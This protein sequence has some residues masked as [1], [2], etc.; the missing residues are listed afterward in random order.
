M[1]NN[2]HIS[3]SALSELHDGAWHWAYS[4]LDRDADAADEVLQDVYVM[5]L[6]GRAHFDNRATLKTWLYSVIRHTCRSHRRTKLR[7]RMARWRY[8]TAEQSQAEQSQPARFHEGT[9]HISPVLVQAL[10]SLPG[11]QRDVIELHLFRGFSLSEC[12]TVLG[13]R[14]GSVR[15][16]Y[17]RAKDN[18]RRQVTQPGEV[19]G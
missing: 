3:Q 9:L 19:G 11:R 17:H 13:L 2:S 18:L 12:A 4:Q 1:A 10:K 6:E 8:F 15:T 7:Y 5:I 16:H 14:V